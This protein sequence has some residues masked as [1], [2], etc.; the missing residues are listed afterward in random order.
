[1]GCRDI[2]IEEHIHKSQYQNEEEFWYTRS[3]SQSSRLE[4]KRKFGIGFSYDAVY[5]GKCDINSIKCHALNVDELL[6]HNIAREFP[7]DRLKDTTCI[8]HTFSEFC[9]AANLTGEAS[10]DVIIYTADYSKVASIYEHGL[11]TVVD[12]SKSKNNL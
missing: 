1:M 7:L 11:D 5:G 8:A 3:L 10:G 2:F 9:H 4:L 6:K 12:I